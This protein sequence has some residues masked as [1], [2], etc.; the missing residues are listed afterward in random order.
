MIE[1]KIAKLE[2]RV[3]DLENQNASLRRQMIRV[4]HLLNLVLEQELHMSKEMDDLVAEVQADTDATNAVNTLL[5]SLEQQ[6]KDAG[7]DTAKLADLT[8]QLAANR[9][10]LSAAVTANTPAATPIDPNAPATLP[11]A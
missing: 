11:G 7:T 5:T 10:I 1:E 6:I 2:K 8:K 4:E 3:S 9:A